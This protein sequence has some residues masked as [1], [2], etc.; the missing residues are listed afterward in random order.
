M[1]K[2]DFGGQGAKDTAIYMPFYRFPSSFLWK[3]WIS[4][5]FNENNQFL[6]IKE[7][8]DLNLIFSYDS[9]EY[10]EKNTEVVDNDENEIL[11]D[12]IEDIEPLIPTT[13]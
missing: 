8:I 5:E 12:I 4:A 9:T 11:T 10:S 2:W 6:S 3:V 13:A 7:L 1:W